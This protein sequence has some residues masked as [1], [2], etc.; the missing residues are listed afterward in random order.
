MSKQ[1]CTFVLDRLLFGIE[2]EKVQEVIR[3]QEM[4]PVLTAPD[5]IAGLMNLRGQIVTA[6]DLRRRMGLPKN[7]EGGLPMNV[8]ICTSEG[9]VSLLVDRIGEVVETEPETFESLPDS[10]RGEVRQ[11]T[12]GVYKL[13]HG[14]L[15]VLNLGAT[16][17]GIVTSGGSP[18]TM[19]AA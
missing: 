17:D 14:L 19:A 4:T 6:V 7:E 12:T 8:V 15:H 11:T 16:L 1:F 13:E 3:Y 2:V 10:V 18:R 5:S 9:A